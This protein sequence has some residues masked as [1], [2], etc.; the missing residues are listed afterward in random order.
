VAILAIIGVGVAIVGIVGHSTP[1]PATP[2]TIYGSGAL[3]R[4]QCSGSGHSRSCGGL[5]PPPPGLVDRLILSSSS[6]RAGN[7]LEATLVVTN[8]TR[9]QREFRDPHGCEP[10]FQIV[11]TNSDWPPQAIFLAGCVGQGLVIKPGTNVF[12]RQTIT[13]WEFCAQEASFA[14]PKVPA[15]IDGYLP[16]PMPPGQ[17]FAVLIGDGSVPLPPAAAGPLTI[18]GR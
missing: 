13:R 12:R 17:Y 11:L 3:S 18:V 16:P 1:T 8:E 5:L 6:V 15:C 7:S 10:Q 2:E 9:S 14:S 4:V